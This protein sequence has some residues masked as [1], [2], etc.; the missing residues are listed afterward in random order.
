MKEPTAAYRTVTTDKS[1]LIDTI[2]P[3]NATIVSVLLKRHEKKGER[4]GCKGPGV[5]G[6]P[7]VGIRQS[8]RGSQ[9]MI[10]PIGQIE[11]HGASGQAVPPQKSEALLEEAGDD[12]DHG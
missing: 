12:R 6:D 4:G 11:L 2:T 5:V 7:L 10:C 1:G 3:A 8:A 9:V